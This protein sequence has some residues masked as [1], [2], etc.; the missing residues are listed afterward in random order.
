MLTAEKDTISL[1]NRALDAASR[2]GEPRHY[3]SILVLLA[4]HNM[5]AHA[6]ERY[7][8]RMW[9]DA[10][11][12]FI[13][14]EIWLEHD[15]IDEAVARLERIGLID[16]RQ[17]Q[18]DEPYDYEYLPMAAFTAKGRR[19]LQPITWEARWGRGAKEKVDG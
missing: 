10:H 15:V 5:M 19:S 13:Q 18:C 11:S 16:I 9:V 1:M 7:R 14:N 12:H 17:K 2:R 6:T 3:P 8:G 4:L